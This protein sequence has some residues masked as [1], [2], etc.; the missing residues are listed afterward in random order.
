MVARTFLHYAFPVVNLFV[1][2]LL[3]LASYADFQVSKV[4]F[5]RV[6]FTVY[7]AY[8]F[9]SKHAGN[10]N[11]AEEY[12]LRDAEGYN[13]IPNRVIELQLPVDTIVFEDNS[14]SK[15][16]ELL[17]AFGLFQI[18]K[19]LFVD[20]ILGS[21]D[22]DTSQTIC[23][24]ISAENAFKLIGIE[25]SFMYDLFYTK[26][27]SAY[28]PWGLGLRL[29]SFTLTII[30]LVLFSLTS[31]KQNYKKV[32]L[33][34]TFLLLVVAIL[35]EIY[36]MLVLISSDWA[37]VWLSLHNKTSISRAITSLAVFRYPHWSNSMAQYSLLSFILQEKPLGGF[38]L[39][40]KFSTLEQLEQQ[41]YITYVKVT[42]TLKEW[43]FNHLNEKLKE[44]QQETEDHEDFSNSRGKI[45]LQKYGFG[46]L[47][48]TTEL[49]FDQSILIWH[50]ATE[51]CNN[52]EDSTEDQVKSKQEISTQLSQYMMYLLV[53]KSPMLPTGIG[54]FVLED[55]CADAKTFISTEGK[56]D[57]HRKLLQQ[58]TTGLQLPGERYRSKKSVLSD[59]CRLADVLT[60]ISNKEEK[61]SM[62]ADVWVEMLAYVAS[63]SNGRQHAEQLTGGGEF[64]THFWLLMA[65]LGLTEHFQIPQRH[66][67]TRLVLR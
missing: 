43:I 21:R 54:E 38:T 65:H 59:S 9:N 12:R 35:L 60:N 46:E 18:Y 40:K 37:A 11:L 16:H 17:A 8:N 10:S 51:M 55:T 22:R 67:V 13:V 44:R 62:I 6:L 28:N 2:L 64:L 7:C 63:Q 53:T 34:I 52:L 39:L 42:G 3:L 47:N 19:G 4:N 31:E 36:A 33:S 50:I 15:D 27:T 24:N 30:V 61:W 66:A 41:R 1:I 23:R 56:I 49:E 5:L 57:V 48:W 45:A 25:C 20:L 58:F 26:A 29:I 32:D 14:I